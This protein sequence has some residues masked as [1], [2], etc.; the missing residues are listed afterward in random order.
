MEPAAAAT[1]AATLAGTLAT[2][3]LSHLRRDRGSSPVVASVPA[4]AEVAAAKAAAALAWCTA[5]GQAMAGAAVPARLR[6]DKSLEA[7]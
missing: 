7:R 4:A 5:A 6:L 1:E 3:R 2:K